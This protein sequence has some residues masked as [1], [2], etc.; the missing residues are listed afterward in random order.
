M[1]SFDI[2]LSHHQTN[3]SDDL[4]E[5]VA[6]LDFFGDSLTFLRK[7]PVDFELAP[8]LAIAKIAELEPD[9]VICCGMAESR[10]K[11]T[12]ES[13]ATRGEDVIH[14]SIDLDRILRHLKAT[15]ISHYAGRFVCEALYYSILTY[16]RDRN[17]QTPCLFVHVPLLTPENSELILADLLSTIAAV[18]EMTAIAAKPI[19]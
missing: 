6:Q 5:Q 4:L 8:Q 10:S 12:L 3:S 2:W 1:T 19:H 17:L 11:L 16:L 13:R 7:L 9:L 18:S 15:E 14:T